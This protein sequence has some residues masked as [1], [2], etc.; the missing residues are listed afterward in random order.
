MDAKD[1]LE[2]AA[3]AVVCNVETTTRL[4]AELERLQAEVV[5]RRSALRFIWGKGINGEL[6]RPLVESVQRVLQRDLL[7]MEF[8]F[9]VRG[10]ECGVQRIADEFRSGAS[11]M[12]SRGPAGCFIS[13]SRRSAR[14]PDKKVAA[15]AM[16]GN[17]MVAAFCCIALRSFIALRAHS[18]GE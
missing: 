6:P 10:V 3:R 7:G 15:A 17:L 8:N 14:V 16:G 5:D 13:R 4:T 9:R 12:N 11:I 2:R 18:P 1:R